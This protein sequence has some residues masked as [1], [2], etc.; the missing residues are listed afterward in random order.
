MIS[1]KQSITATIDGNGIDISF[2]EIHAFLTYHC[3]KYSVWPGPSLI[4]L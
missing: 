1:L 4:V 3:A 2:L